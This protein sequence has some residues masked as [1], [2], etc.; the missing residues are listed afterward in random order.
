MTIVKNTTQALRRTG[1]A[2]G[3]FWPAIWRIS[4]AGPRRP[5]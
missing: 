3:R 1:Q 2:V 5:S 4:A